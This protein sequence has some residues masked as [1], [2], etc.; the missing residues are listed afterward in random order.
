M[1]KSLGNVIIPGKVIKQLGAD[2]LRLWVASVD[3]Q[4]DVRISD[5]ILKQVAEVY[6]KIRNTFRFMLGN[7]NDFNPAKDTVKE[8]DLQEVDRYMLVKLQ[9]VLRKV[10]KAYDEYEFSTIYHVV[11][12]FVTI[13]LSAFYLDFAKDILYIEPEND[14]RRRSIQTV[15]YEILTTLAKV[16]SP[17]LAHTSDELWSYIPG[18]EEESIQLTDIPKAREIADAD[19]LKAKW[20]HFIEVRDDVLKALEEAR[21]EKVIGKSLEAKVTIVP[22]DEKTKTILTDVEHLHQ[23]LIVSE[24]NVLDNHPDAKEYNHVKVLVEKHSAEKCQR[25]WV[26]SDT[27]GKNEEHPD[28]CDRCA[29]IVATHY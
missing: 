5:D 1:S 13:D 9:D 15:Y 8:E 24:A 23:Y 28:L 29:D 20:D 19:Q 14:A 17:I 12:N 10:T 2:I 18:V 7:L 27:V 22:K 16:M 21:A 3:Y 4:A 6:R 25:C 26:A 11:Q